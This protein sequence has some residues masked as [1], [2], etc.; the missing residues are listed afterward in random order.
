MTDPDKQQPE[1]EQLQLEQVILLGVGAGANIA[2]RL[3][4]LVPSTV[5]GIIAL[6]PTAA[7]AGIMEQVKV[8]GHL[9]YIFFKIP[10]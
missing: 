5:L 7:A 3:A 2:C 6:Q 8:G 1:L 4:L 9:N 10:T